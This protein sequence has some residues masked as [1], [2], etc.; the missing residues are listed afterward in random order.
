[1][2]HLLKSVGMKFLLTIFLCLILANPVYSYTPFPWSGKWDMK[3]TSNSGTSPQVPIELEHVGGSYV[4]SLLSDL[5]MG[6]PTSEDGTTW[7]GKWLPASL[8]EVTKCDYSGEFSLK[9]THANHFQGSWWCGIDRMHRK[10]PSGIEYPPDGSIV[11]TRSGTPTAQGQT[12]Q[13]GTVPPGSCSCDKTKHLVWDGCEGCNCVCEKKFKF[14]EVGD[15]VPDLP[16][17]DGS[18][19]EEALTLELETL[20]GRKPIEPGQTKVTLGQGA[21]AKLIARCQELESLIFVFRLEKGLGDFPGLEPLLDKDE[22]PVLFTLFDLAIWDAEY[23]RLNCKDLL[24]ENKPRKIFEG[25]SWY[26]LEASGSK[27]IPFKLI[28][29]EGPM[30]IE[31]MQDFVTLELETPTTL[32]SSSGKNRFAAGYDPSKSRTIIAALQNPIQVQPLGANQATFIL[33]PGQKVEIGQNNVGPITSVGQTPTGNADGASNYVSPD[34]KDISGQTRGS[35]LMGGST[36][37]VPSERPDITGIWYMGGPHDEGRPCQILH[38]GN[39]LIFINENGGQSGGGFVDSGTVVASDW[40]GLQGKISDGGKRIDW[41]NGSWWVRNS[42]QGNSQRPSSEGCYQDPLTGEITCVDASGNPS[43]SVS[44]Q[45]NLQEP[46]SGGCYQDP[47][48]GKITCV[49]TSGNSGS[50]VSGQGNSQGP[51]S[52]GCYQD[53]VTGEI[54]CVDSTG[55]PEDLSAP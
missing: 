18:E 6:G 23:K 19:I 45:G 3:V 37:S 47:Y 1:V 9:L 27:L 7:E 30:D 8:P 24:R 54:T 21:E 11:A 46:S 14:N 50:S 43:N 2:L 48:T 20:E 28:L 13:T 41:S 26:S 40:Q 16:E 12:S 51:S 17:T 36:G 52:G 4:H 33:G 35:N 44:G 39:A 34:G 38:N 15:C 25:D 29:K 22:S 42:Q 49:D 5:N 32:V 10:G 31:I 53:P 55:T